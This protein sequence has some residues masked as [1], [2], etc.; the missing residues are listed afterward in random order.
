ML[1][2]GYS[3]DLFSLDMTKSLT[4]DGPEYLDDHDHMECVS[5]YPHFDNI[6][7]KYRIYRTGE[8]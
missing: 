1:P 3:V 4:V 5:L 2:Y 7:K 8:L 6:T